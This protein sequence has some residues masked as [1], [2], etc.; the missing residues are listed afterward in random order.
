MRST[1]AGLSSADH[2]AAHQGDILTTDHTDNTDEKTDPGLAPLL[3]HVIGAIRGHPVLHSF[4]RLTRQEE[5]AGLLDDTATIGTRSG[6]ADRLRSMG[7]VL[8]GRRL[9]RGRRTGFPADDF[10]R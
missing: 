8:R 2:P 5:R 3:I 7:Y 6:W 1:D 10:A 4:D 9:I